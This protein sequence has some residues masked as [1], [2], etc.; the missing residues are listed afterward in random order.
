MGLFPGAFFKV[1]FKVS[2]TFSVLGPCLPDLLRP[3]W[4]ASRLFQALSATSELTVAFFKA[5][6]R[7]SMSAEEETGWSACCRADH[8]TACLLSLR[9]GPTPSCPFLVVFHPFSK[10]QQEAT[11]SRLF[12]AFF[13]AGRRQTKKRKVLACVC[14]CETMD[15][16]YIMLD[17]LPLVPN[18]F[19]CLCLCV[20]GCVFL[21]VAVNHG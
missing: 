15:M 12:Q 4:L 8:W 5:A 6:S 14:C 19:V 3:F 17:V 20:C 1:S 10:N 9:G 2:A 21:I 16:R 11:F 7:F 18:V 13:K